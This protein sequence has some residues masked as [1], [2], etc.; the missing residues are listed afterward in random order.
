MTYESQRAEAAATMQQINEAWRKGRPQDLSTLVHPEIIMVL[1]NFAGKIAGRESFLAGFEDFCRNAKL[2]ELQEHDQQID[3]VDATAVVSFR[4]E[5]THERAG[6][7][8]RSTGR[9]LWL[10]ERQ[11]EKW[12]AVWRT[13]LDMTEQVL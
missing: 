1:P 6:A 2:E 13:M 5:M 3:V 7:R 11:R 9:D 10:F 4:F 12:I 8:Y